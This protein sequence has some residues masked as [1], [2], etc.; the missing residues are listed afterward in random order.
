MGLA[1]TFNDISGSS[2]IVAIGPSESGSLF[3]SAHNPNP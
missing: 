3:V 1:F 2:G